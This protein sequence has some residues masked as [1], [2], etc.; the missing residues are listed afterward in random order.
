MDYNDKK[1]KMYRRIAQRKILIFLCLSVAIATSLASST[2]V[3]SAASENK[4]LSQSQST[5]SMATNNTKMN[6]V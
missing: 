5:Q 6:I 1:H 2:Y 3:V 4:T